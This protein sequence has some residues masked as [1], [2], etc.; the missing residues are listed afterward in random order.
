MSRETTSP[1][2]TP[3]VLMNLYSRA[4]HYTEV[5]WIN[6]TRIILGVTMV[7]WIAQAI[8]I[9]SRGQ[10]LVLDDWLI[11]MILAFENAGKSLIEQIIVYKDRRN[12]GYP[13][14]NDD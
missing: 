6:W 5:S 14:P 8:F 7:V 12:N 10:R 9:F 2:T 3:P 1:K 13:K 11:P 4:K